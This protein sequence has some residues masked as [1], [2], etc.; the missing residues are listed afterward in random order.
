MCVR[1]RVRAQMCTLVELSCPEA[2]GETR[3][4]LPHKPTLLRSLLSLRPWALLRHGWLP[5]LER[6]GGASLPGLHL[7]LLPAASSHQDFSV[8][9]PS[10]PAQECRFPGLNCSFP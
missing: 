10:F 6:V 8:Q 7:K 9:S 3:L 5:V 4:S 2:C 1:V